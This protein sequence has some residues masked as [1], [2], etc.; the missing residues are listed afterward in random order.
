MLTAVINIMLETD[1]TNDAPT[2]IRLEYK[3][4]LEID[5]HAVSMSMSEYISVKCAAQ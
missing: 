3:I 1:D 2:C 5:E 4:V